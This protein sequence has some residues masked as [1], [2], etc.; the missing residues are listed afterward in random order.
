MLER[1]GKN[2]KSIEKTKCLSGP[3]GIDDYEDM[4]KEIAELV[5][6]VNYPAASCG[7]SKHKATAK[8]KRSKLRGIYP[9]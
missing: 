8:K 4:V 3:G 9:Q 2:R 1:I 6:A 7:A 5:E